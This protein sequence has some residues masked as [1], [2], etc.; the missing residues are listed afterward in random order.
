MNFCTLRDK[1]C[2]VSNLQASNVQ[3]SGANLE[4]LQGQKL[5]LLSATDC[6]Q[7]SS[8][9]KP[10]DGINIYQSNRLCTNCYEEIA[11]N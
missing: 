4:E 6:S 8:L 7:C 1:D 5:Q 9:L 11:A 10:E 2:S 3:I